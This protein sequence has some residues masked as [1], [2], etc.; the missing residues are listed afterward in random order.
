MKKPEKKEATVKHEVEVLRVKQFDNGNV[1]CDLKINDVKI[2][3]CRIVE[4]RNG[5][6]V[7]FPQYKGTDGNY[8]SHAFC[9]LSDDEQKAIISKCEEMLD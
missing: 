6:F 8:Y 1:I 7:G 9:F 4:G 2:Y 5:D 3:G